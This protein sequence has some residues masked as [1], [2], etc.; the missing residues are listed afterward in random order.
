MKEEKERERDRERQE[1]AV[2]LWQLAYQLLLLKR[3]QYTV[4]NYS[5]A[6]SPVCISPQVFA[7]DVPF[8]RLPF[9]HPFNGY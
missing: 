8:Y 2:T 5:E 7:S 9:S 6:G 4:F 3:L 1:T